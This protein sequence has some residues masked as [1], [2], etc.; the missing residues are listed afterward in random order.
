MAERGKVTAGIV[1][2]L[3][4]N[5]Q[6]GVWRPGDRIPSENE[7][8]AALGVSRVSVRSALSQM[9]A[10]GILRSV[11]GKGTYLI[12]GDLS[13]FGE[14]RPRSAGDPE[15]ALLAE[16]RQILEFRLFL[17]PSVCAEAA[18]RASPDA[19]ERMGGLLDKMRNSIGDSVGFVDADMKFHLEIA[20]SVGNPLL[21]RVL[22]ELLGQKKEA[23][24]QLNRA[25]GSYGGI[26]YHALILDAL[27]KRDSKRASALMT[28]HLQHSLDEIME[29]LLQ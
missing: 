4:K 19:L 14:A 8:C 3:R 16:M 13:V 5:I 27:N 22:S 12:S 18:L 2:Y 7:L 23:H 6:D 10:L 20:E 21:S 28:E 29:P 17:E 11:H 9:T 25:V 24:T 15:N 26:Y 1:R